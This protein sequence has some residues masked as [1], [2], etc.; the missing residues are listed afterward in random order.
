MKTAIIGL[1]GSGKTSLFAALAGPAAMQSDRAMIK[2]PEPRLDPLIRL[3]VPKKVTLTEI[4]VQDTR[5]A[6]SKGGLGEKILTEIRPF[7]CL[8]AVLDGFT[9]LKAPE[10]QRNEIETDL[11]IAD[12]SVIEKRLERI[13]TDKKKAKGLVDPKEEEFLVQARDILESDRPLRVDQGVSSAP[14]LKGFRFLSAKPVLYAWNFDEE[15]FGARELPPD[16]PGEVH[17]AVSARLERDLVEVTDPEERAMFLGDLGVSGSALERII[18]RTYDLLGLITFLTAGEKEVRSWP[19]KR[20]LTAPEAAGVIH[21]DI[22]KGFIRAEV[23][24]FN[25]LIACGDFKKAKERGLLR[26]EGKEYIVQDGDIITF[27]FNV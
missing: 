10:M 14:E 15:H 16:S 1:S 19:L 27:R 20:G 25:D 24:A 3:F 17:V 22:Q 18:S 23:L 6:G 21:S 2:V 9:G 11:I 4:E 7:D 12:L 5:G 13:A 8:L 26:L